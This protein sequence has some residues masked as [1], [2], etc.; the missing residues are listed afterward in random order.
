MSPIVCRMSH[1]LAVVRA[2]LIVRHLLQ[3][4]VVRR[5]FHEFEN[6]IAR[7]LGVGFHQPLKEL[8]CAGYR[9][10]LEAAG[11]AEVCVAWAL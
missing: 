1:H 4:L 10:P 7:R 6:L 9:P 5:V 8:K 11:V 3:L 2:E